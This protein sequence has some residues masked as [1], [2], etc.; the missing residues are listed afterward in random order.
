MKVQN[1]PGDKEGNTPTPSLEEQ[2]AYWGQKIC[3][4]ATCEIYKRVML[5]S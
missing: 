2:T 5:S 1:N 3:P 4:S